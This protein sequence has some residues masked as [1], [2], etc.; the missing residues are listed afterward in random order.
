M[1]SAFM[2][3]LG[4]LLPI[5]LGLMFVVTG[6]GKLLNP[7]DLLSNVYSYEL[8]S[9]DGGLAVARILPWME[10]IIG[11]AALSGM[12][13]R[14][15]M[16]LATMLFL[17]FV[18]AQ[19]FVVISGTITPC[20]CG[21]LP[22]GEETVGPWTIART[23]FLAGLSGTGYIAV[24]RAGRPREA[25]AQHI[26]SSAPAVVVALFLVMP[27]R[28]VIDKNGGPL[29]SEAAHRL[30]DIYLENM[31]LIVSYME[32][33]GQVPDAELRR[34]R[35]SSVR[36]L[37]QMQ[38]GL[39][40]DAIV[41]PMPEGGFLDFASIPVS[42]LAVAGEMQ[43]FVAQ[44]SSRDGDAGR[45]GAA[46]RTTTNLMQYLRGVGSLSATNASQMVGS[47]LSEYTSDHALL[48]GTPQADLTL[49]KGAFDSLP[50]DDPFGR[51]EAF[52]K[53]GQTVIDW[54]VKARE[55]P[56][57][58]G[59][60][61]QVAQYSYSSLEGMADMTDGEILMATTQA[62]RF[63]AAVAEAAGLDERSESM[64]ALGRLQKSAE[65]GEFGPFAAAIVDPKF[66]AGLSDLRVKMDQ[67]K[68]LVEELLESVGLALEEGPALNGA[69]FYL[70]AVELMKE[71]KSTDG[72]VADGVVQKLAEADEIILL[73]Q[74]G[75]ECDWCD[76]SK[77]KDITSHLLPEYV[78][79]LQQCIKLMYD[80]EAGEQSKNKSDERV[81]QLL[82]IARHLSGDSTLASSALATQAVNLARLVLTKMEANAHGSEE[83]LE[84]VLS[85]MNAMDTS[86][87]LGWMN[88]TR[89]IRRAWWAK[90][91]ILM[92]VDP[93]DM[94]KTYGSFASSV[95]PQIA[96]TGLFS[97]LSQ[98]QQET[99]VVRIAAFDR[100]SF[101][102]EALYAAAERA[103]GFIESNNQDGL[104]G[105]DMSFL[106]ELMPSN[107]VGL[108]VWAE[109][110][111]SV[112][113][114][115]KID[116][117]K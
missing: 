12:F 16:L 51:L 37:T 71:A 114:K 96:W 38:R 87:P 1:K 59:L 92:S 93:L 44:L 68:E 53:Q 64:A 41:F 109:F 19:I 21:L 103:R 86:D 102:V 46:L 73:M 55:T 42:N 100:D 23:A 28:G 79:W 39:R 75:A 7:A 56:E 108:D 110:R 77:V 26:A 6:A 13:V 61:D 29:I 54:A 97:L 30:S 105:L 91:S 98:S 49:L 113:S 48:N 8:L 45:A 27:A 99:V 9:E 76:F 18:L 32:Q 116:E 11:L 84:N 36:W 74:T 67:S 115:A 35:E 65:A 17:I 57:G 43:M 101:D 47:L 111:R 104:F 94:W 88:A 24:S 3:H 69:D 14:G 89:T 33:G 70:A 66:G 72:K 106:D 22:L 34:I 40:S 58:R 25:R 81:V 31:P 83:V 50:P 112:S 80:H 60:L 85:E 5:L 78:P 117:S 63:F 82:R 4:V 10:L 2:T 15:A 107:A 95:E 20:G 90:W 62:D 52:R